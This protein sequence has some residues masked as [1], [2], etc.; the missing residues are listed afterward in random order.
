MN[1]TMAVAYPY[2]DDGGFDDDDIEFSLLSHTF[3]H[4]YRMQ[5][6]WNV[7]E[8]L[9]MLSGGNAQDRG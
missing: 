1:R 3:T 7:C 2:V 8:T 6:L 5:Y 9:K 4:I